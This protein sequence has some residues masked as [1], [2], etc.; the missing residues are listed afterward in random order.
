M[1]MV[2]DFITI[3]HFRI[4][5]VENL[6][7]SDF[8]VVVC[9][10][11]SEDQNILSEMGCKVINIKMNR[12]GA[13][14]FQEISIIK[15]Y[16]NI[17]KRE[18]P[19]LLM[20]FT[21]KPNLYAG[22]VARL[23]KTKVIHTVTGLGSVFLTEK[24]F[25]PVLLSVN[26]IAFKNANAVFFLNNDNKE[27][28]IDLKLADQTSKLIVIPGSGV[29]LNK[30]RFTPLERTENI[31]FSFFGRIIKDKGIIELLEASRIVK[32]NYPNIV[33]NIFG[34]IDDESIGDIVKTFNSKGI[35]NYHGNTDE[36]YNEITK[37]HCIILPSYGEGR[38]TIL[39]EAS[40]SG[41]PI[42]TTDTFGCRDNVEDGLNGFLI[43][44]R[45]VNALVDGFRKFLNLSFEEKQRMGIYGN[46]KALKEYD[47]EHIVGNYLLEINNIIERR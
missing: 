43:E 13:N 14:P 21:I 46:K 16:Y 30:F 28:Y 17:V 7:V 35:V 9:L 18:K 41:R 36:V 24:W 44:V 15:Q 12:R 20:T 4:E 22:I 10:P 37:S 40:A 38:G 26:R 31:V 32:S 11:Y 29:N 3:K 8:D 1:I 2:N 19:D 45:N 47:R 34:L 5:L 6:I 25:K 23:T 27:T 39:Q 42:I 33:I